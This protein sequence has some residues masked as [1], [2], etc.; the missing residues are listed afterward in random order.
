MGSVN[1]S[2]IKVST[3]YKMPYILYSPTLNITG[4]NWLFQDGNTCFILKIIIIRL[5]ITK[6][7]G[8]F[9]PFL[10]QNMQVVIFIFLKYNQK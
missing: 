9:R 10:A 7:K 1:I 4:Y 2:V 5:K 6:E 3:K 8:E